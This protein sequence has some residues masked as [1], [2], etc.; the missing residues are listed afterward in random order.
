M[1]RFIL[2]VT[3][4]EQSL[5]LFFSSYWQLVPVIF[6][7]GLIRIALKQVVF[8]NSLLAFMILLAQL[9][10]YIAFFAFT[11]IVVD[12]KHQGYSTSF[13][14]TLLETKQRYPQMLLAY[15]VG[16]FLVFT[17]VCSISFIMMLPTVFPI[18]LAIK[19]QGLN[20]LWDSLANSM[21]VFGNQLMQGFT[22]GFL[23]QFTF[24]PL[25][26]INIVTYLQGGHADIVEMIVIGFC[27]V[28]TLYFFLTGIFVVLK[29]Q[30]ALEGIKSSWNMIRRDWLTTSTLVLYWI[31][32]LLCI[33]RVLFE[34]MGN[35]SSEWV[36]IATFS[37]GPCLMVIQ[38]SNLSKITA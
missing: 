36:S 34:F 27:F 32:L 29:K 19:I 18:I 38:Y 22:F 21:M 28:L 16:T 14:S 10:I 8:E 4:F 17:L 5:K 12:Q 13:N 24:Y 23:Q 15:G 11:L 7:Y 37:L 6:T 9:F 33:N 3:L 1:K 2:A 30:P 35:A 26:L 25:F 31:L 20:A